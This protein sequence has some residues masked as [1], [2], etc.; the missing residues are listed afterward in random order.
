M[1]D[2]H[3]EPGRPESTRLFIDFLRGPVRRCRALYILGDLFEVWIG[4]DGAGALASEVAT[5]LREVAASGVEVYFLC[6]NRDFLLGDDYCRLAGMRRLEEPVMLPGASPATAMLHGDSLCT[7]DHDYQRF[8]ARVRDP[9]WQARALSRPLWWRR[10]LARLARRISAYRNRGKPDRIMDV[11]AETVTET[12]R[13][14]GARR[15]IH[16]HTHRPAIHRGHIDQQPVARIV[17]GDWHGGRGSAVRVDPDGVSLLELGYGAAGE[18][19]L[20]IRDRD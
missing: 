15:L 3:L 16:G 7:D 6:G 2:L 13:Q 18:I 20:S 12:F 8:R 4:D 14:L 9:A 1:A 11:N 5:E 19:E 10:L 17:L